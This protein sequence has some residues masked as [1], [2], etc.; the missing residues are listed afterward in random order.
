MNSVV[1]LHYQQS[2]NIIT[3]LKNINYENS[4]KNK[5]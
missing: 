2:N 1:Y 5:R 3:T 4:S